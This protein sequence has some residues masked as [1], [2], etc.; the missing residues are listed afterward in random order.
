MTRRLWGMWALILVVLAG[1]LWAARGYYQFGGFNDDAAYVIR[2]DS[3]RH[4]GRLIPTLEQDGGSGAYFP[5]YS[6][7]LAG[8][9]TL[10]TSED[11]LHFFSLLFTLA[12]STCLMLL[13]KRR[14]PT[15]L[16][17][18]VGMSYVLTPAGLSCGTI[19]MSDVPFAALFL[20][21]ILWAEG[22]LEHDR[23][24]WHWIGLLVSVVFL[25]RLPGVVLFP[26]FA[27]PLALRKR[28]RAIAL[29]A[30][31]CVPGAMYQLASKLV[32][33]GGTGNYSDQVG[34][35]YARFSL[36]DQQSAFW[37]HL[38]S[39]LSDSF[40]GTS[41]WLA[42]F[43]VMA[44]S[45][46]ALKTVVRTFWQPCSLALLGFMAFSSIWFVLEP[47]YMLFVWPLL[48]MLAVQRLPPKAALALVAVL[49]LGNLPL[50]AALIRSRG[51][52]LVWDQRR[53]AY[54]SI[55]EQ[56]RPEERLAG[57]MTT[58]LEYHT[59]RQVRP[60]GKSAVWSVF[61]AGAVA[62]G[63]SVLVL[64]PDD[65]LVTLQGTT[66]T[67][68]PRHAKEW[69]DHSSLVEKIVDT[70]TVHAYRI[71]PEA[72]NLER[73]LPLFVQGAFAEK[74]PERKKLYLRKALQV[75]PDFPDAVKALAVLEKN[76]ELLER[77]IAQYPVDLEAYY[78]LASMLEDPRRVAEEGI[79]QARLL[80]EPTA[81]LE[82]FT[83]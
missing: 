28:W 60:P 76:P 22:A 8:L 64:E 39:H 35:Y 45:L 21:A 24:Q 1:A 18:L 73:A 71:K 7:L 83:R 79:A 36:W 31:G 9:R 26:A 50:E 32:A 4:T 11:A 46:L 42:W 3:I 44:I 68:T 70:P 59:Q 13:A 34:R 75:C 48:L 38:F 72:R 49:L 41:T 74:E 54:A 77:E 55:R 30:L 63:A 23:Q 82:P 27:L 29:L 33:I 47:R 43:V 57:V 6:I 69:A 25:V 17:F 51:S 58:S 20:A 80:G 65:A 10:T 16:A 78:L 40:L 15:T 61:L 81:P 53:A 14:L 2:A 56:T 66:T 52:Q 5:G 62:Q 67:D 37:G 19:V 12:G